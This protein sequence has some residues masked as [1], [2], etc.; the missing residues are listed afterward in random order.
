[1]TINLSR[2]NGWYPSLRETS[3]VRR[4][5]IRESAE[6]VTPCAQIFELDID[7]YIEID[8][9]YFLYYIYWIRW[10]REER[11]AVPFYSLT[12]AKKK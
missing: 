8:L 2:Y 9:I 7:T 1:M 6:D 4:F 5:A 3:E 10:S 12:N 11:E